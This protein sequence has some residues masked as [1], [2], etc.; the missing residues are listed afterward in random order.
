MSTVAAGGSTMTEA[1]AAISAS[2][3]AGD[4]GSGIQA[5]LPRT[6]FIV[7]VVAA[8]TWMAGGGRERPADVA[9]RFRRL[10]SAPPDLRRRRL[11]AIG[12][13]DW[14]ELG[15]WWRARWGRGRRRSGGTSRR[16]MMAK[17]GMESVDVDGGEQAELA[18]AVQK[19][20]AERQQLARRCSPAP[21]LLGPKPVPINRCRWTRT[22]DRFAATHSDY[23]VV[24][25]SN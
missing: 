13:G 17:V 25:L 18:H 23:L 11:H 21:D 2:T 20:S 19:E 6:I 8:T 5:R 12:S 16:M 14:A 7:V 22:N 3:E 24:A 1:S 10:G 9:R 15:R 4:A